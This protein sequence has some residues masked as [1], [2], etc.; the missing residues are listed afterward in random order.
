MA[1][2]GYVYNR[3]AAEMRSMSSRILGLVVANIRNP[4]F[5]ELTMA[6]ESTAH[7][8]GYNLILGCSSDD[9]GRQADVLRAM[10]E[11]RVD[12]IILLPASHSTPADLEKSL[13][14]RSL[15]HALVARA[16]TGYSCDYVGADNEASGVLIGKHLQEN[17]FRKIAFLGGVE[18]STPRA[19]RIRGLMRGLGPDIEAFCA[20]VASDVDAGAGLTGLVDQAFETGTV[21]DAIVAYN[22][23][24]AF[25]IASA[26]RARGVEPG[27]DVALASFDN[28][29]EAAQQ[30]PSLTSADGFPARVGAA[31][32]ELVLSAI[33]DPTRPAQ[34]VLIAP[35]LEVRDSTS[36]RP[37][38][39]GLADQTAV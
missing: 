36:P 34:R 33:A 9:V 22:D 28:V 29:P 12:G 37:H 26:L 2:V 18:G 16:V 24:H 13:R 23:M 7:D 10:A 20:D 21:P 15:P 17:G 6:I 35:E 25:S 1:A 8:A 31:A 30:Y 3:R 11:H 19:D 38:P 5:A 39:M 27:R 14:R 4:Y 32:T